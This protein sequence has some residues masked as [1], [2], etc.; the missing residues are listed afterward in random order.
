[1][2][3]RL[4]SKIIYLQF[5]LKFTILQQQP[6]S[7]NLRVRG[8]P[9]HNESQP[10][11][12][13]PVETLATIIGMTQDDIAALF[14]PA[15]PGEL[16]KG[17][18]WLS[19]TQVCRYWR[20]CALLFPALWRNITLGSDNR[21]DG[22]LG[23]TFLLNSGS[24]PFHFNY[25][26][27]LSTAQDYFSPLP[28]PLHAFFQKFR[29]NSYRLEA[30]H[31]WSA[32]YIQT[33][34]WDFLDHPLP[35]L[36][37]LH[38]DLMA[39]NFPD[40]PESMH[41]LPIILGGN[42]SYLKRLSLCSIGSWSSNV[43]S[44]LTHLSL[45][46]QEDRWR[47][48]LSQFLNSIEALPHLQVLFLHRAGPILTLSMT[49]PTRN[50]TLLAL[51]RIE[52]GCIYQPEVEVPCQLLQYL[53][54]PVNVT[55]VIYSR[56][57]FRSVAIFRHHLPPTIYMAKITSCDI[58]MTP[59]QYLLLHEHQFIIN[60]MISLEACFLLLSPLRDVSH[61]TEII[62]NRPFSLPNNHL[63]RTV[64]PAFPA[65]RS[66]H[67]KVPSDYTSIIEA[68]RGSIPFVCVDFAQLFV[69]DLGIDLATF[70]PASHVAIRSYQEAGVTVV[71]R[72][73]LGTSY[74]VIVCPYI[75][76]TLRRRRQ[77]LSLFER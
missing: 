44:E 20:Q 9:N 55:I 48:S 1:M 34:I 22:R 31:M 25:V 63:R 30:L 61:V 45:R 70:R 52:I 6:P 19:T 77:L 50:I 4:Y 75:K 65:L 58:R 36:L 5:T 66:I 39:A 35:S 73:G 41:P 24:T 76:S 43:F 60:S 2:L 46:N 57:M 68:L 71:Q 11:N 53:N 38:L 10:I 26:M 33:G 27:K 51:R 74:Q 18:S 14:P 8:Y 49:I 69:C 42:T 37:S 7:Q 12:Q 59:G 17:N 56:A 28:T 3:H 16:R 15:T 40:G 13:L 47:P 72:R 62:I 64:L 32:H 21:D 29:D 54:M 67:I 23:T